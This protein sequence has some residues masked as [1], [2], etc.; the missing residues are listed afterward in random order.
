MQLVA[1]NVQG[2]Y[3]WYKDGTLQSSNGSG[4]TATSAGEYWVVILKN[5]CSSE[6]NHITLSC[7]SVRVKTGEANNEVVNVQKYLKVQPNPAT[8]FLDVQWKTTNTSQ[9]S[10]HIL[11]AEGKTVKTITTQGAVNQQRITLN[12]LAKGVYMLV[13]KTGADQQV[14]KFVIQ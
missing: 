13:L 7:P 6:S 11:N 8:N 3:Q 12:G 10:I 4:F 5:G 9:T 1:S 2:T 14:S